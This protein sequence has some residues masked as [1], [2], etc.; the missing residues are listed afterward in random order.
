VLVETMQ[1]VL[2]FMR[3]NTTVCNVWCMK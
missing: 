1:S 2:F 3:Y